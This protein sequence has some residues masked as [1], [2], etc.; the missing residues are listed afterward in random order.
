MSENFYLHL[1]DCSK[2]SEHLQDKSIDA[3]IT[4]LPYCISKKNNFKTMKNRKGRNGIFFGD[5][6]EEFDL[7]ILLKFV[8]KLKDGGCLFTF[9]SFD[10]YGSLIDILSPHMDIK[11]RVVWKK[12]NPMPRNRDRRYVSNIEMATWWVTKKDDGRLTGSM[13][14]TMDAYLHTLLNPE[15]VTKGFIHAKKV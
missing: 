15:A 13:L 5:W 14:L 7:S 2:F 1:G 6:D 9:H 12:S 8:P 11:D 4:D 10:Q 3:I